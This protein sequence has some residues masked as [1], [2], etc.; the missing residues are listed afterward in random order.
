[1]HQSKEHVLGQ[2]CTQKTMSSSFPLPH[3]K[4][5]ELIPC[6]AHNI[7]AADLLSKYPIFL[8]DFIYRNYLL[9]FHFLDPCSKHSLLK[10]IH[11][12]CQS[13]QTLIDL[14]SSRLGYD[15]ASYWPLLDRLFLQGIINTS[16]LI[17]NQ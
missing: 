7:H 11:Y 14:P 9:E 16:R 1:M 5:L 17:F 15:Y 12:Q 6:Q 2:E 4:V 10:S 3:K 13:V 8:K